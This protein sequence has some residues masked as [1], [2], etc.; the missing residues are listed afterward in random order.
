M[1]SGVFRKKYVGLYITVE[2]KEP[3]TR[4]RNKAEEGRRKNAW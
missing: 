1:E 4:V 3:G 2:I